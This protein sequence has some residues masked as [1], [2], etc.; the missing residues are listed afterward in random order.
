MPSKAIVF[1]IALVLFIAL[2][3]SIIEFFLPLSAKNEMNTICRKTLLK[4]EL[5]GGMTVAMRDELISAL[6]GK[7]F[8]TVVIEG[9]ENAKYGQEISLYVEAYYVYSRLRGILSREDTVQRMVYNKTT[10]ARKVLN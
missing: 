7:G 5:E 1:G 8:R 3:V 9:T 2:F 4:M 10:I 6:Y